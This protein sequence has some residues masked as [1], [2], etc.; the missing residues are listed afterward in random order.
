MSE[1]AN[2]KT[3]P[4]RIYLQHGDAPEV[5]A[6]HDVYP[7]NGYSDNVT[8]C[9]D[10][11]EPVDVEYVRADLAAP[12]ASEGYVIAPNFRGYALLGI[13]QYL[14]NHTAPDEPAELILS[15]A[16]EAEKV[17][18]VVGDTR[19][20][21]PGAMIQPEV[22]AVRIG[23]ENVAGL[24][25]LEQQL[26]FL[27]EEHFP[28]TA[29]LAAPAAPVQSI[30]E[31][32]DGLAADAEASRTAATD[33]TLER[34]HLHMREAYQ[35]AAT[36]ARAAQLGAPAAPA[37]DHEADRQRFP[38]PD[39]NRWLDESVSDYHTVWEA[40]GDIAAAW[41]GW[42]NRQFYAAPEPAV[43]IAL[44]ALDRLARLGN[45]PYLGNSH[46]ND[47]AQRAIRAIEAAQPAPAQVDATVI[48]YGTK[49]PAQGELSDT[50]PN[51]PWLSLAHMIC[52][53]AGIPPGHITARLEA[54]RDKLGAPAREPAGWKLVPSEPTEDM[55]IHGFESAPSLGFSKPE[56]WDAYEQMSG[57]QQ[58]AHKARLCYAAMLAAA[59]ETWKVLPLPARV[60]GEMLHQAFPEIP[61]EKWPLP[62][63][64]QAVWNRF[65]ERVNARL[66]T[67][68][69]KQE[70]KD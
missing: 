22:I 12:A 8:W 62:A 1:Q 53:D 31:K 26:R 4:E 17:G 52:A 23:F 44:E 18:R 13:G 63:A 24:D 59:P 50:D 60:T 46:G 3:W 47:I 2:I 7:G 11:I 33:Q 65:A 25:A 66:A 36:L 42:D 68:E 64:R 29:Q 32:L 58:A 41:A 57:C 67:G 51:A 20:N 6:F 54:L 48:D 35:H 40:V 27:R 15:I 10:R 16:T 49:Q 38:D 19:D 21:V 70:S 30:A 5:P 69:P 34:I 45:E 39:F 43:K 9:Q 14:L 55:V 61:G 37:H 28:G 56:E